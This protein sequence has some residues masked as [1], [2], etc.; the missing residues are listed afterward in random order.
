[1]ADYGFDGMIKVSFVPTIANV[2]GPTVAELNAGTALEGRL[3]ADGLSISSDTAS[4]DTSKLNSTANSETIGRDS[5]SLSVTYV[6]GDDSAA[7]SVQAAL[8][9]GAAGYLVVRRDK[10]STVAWA[11]GDKAEV[12]P[13]I[14]KRPNPATPGPDT[15]QTVEVGMSMTDGTKVRAIDNPATVAA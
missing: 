1:M 7:T 10:L 2:A 5:Y 12:Y 3:T 9:R 8:V 14:C 15:L 13:V 6:R 11:A 4:I